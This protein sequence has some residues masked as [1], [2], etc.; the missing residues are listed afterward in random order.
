MGFVVIHFGF[1]VPDRICKLVFMSV[2]DIR[3]HQ[4]CSGFDQEAF[5]VQNRIVIQGSQAR[6]DIDEDQHIHN[7]RQNVIAKVNERL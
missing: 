1:Q 5:S 7:G 2:G 3:L 6:F 4:K